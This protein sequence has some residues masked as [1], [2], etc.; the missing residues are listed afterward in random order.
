MTDGAREKVTLSDEEI[1]ERMMADPEKRERAE[2]LAE[3]VRKG[4]ATSG[5]RL[6]AE[7]LALFLRDSG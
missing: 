4:E 7:E 1:R 3:Q 6:S 5:P 2:K